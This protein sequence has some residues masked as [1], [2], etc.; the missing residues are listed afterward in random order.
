MR[1]KVKLV[2]E[3]K[4]IVVELPEKSRVRDLVKRLGY[5]VQGVVVLRGETPIVEDEFLLDG[6]E[7]KIVLTASGG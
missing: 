2:R 6:D 1:I 3:K 7:L 4:E 5:N